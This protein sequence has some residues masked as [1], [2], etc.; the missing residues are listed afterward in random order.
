MRFT[1]STLLPADCAE[2]FAWHARPGA[3]RRLQ[4]PWMAARIASE[5]GS[6]RH[7][8]AVLAL[9]GGLR[10]VALHEPSKYVEGRRFADTLVRSGPASWP[11]SA[12]VDWQHTH[13][14]EPH[15]T[16]R[17]GEPECRMT[18]V[19]ETN[20]PARMLTPMFT[21]RHEQLA[22][23]LAAHRLAD[24]YRT[25]R[26]PLTVAM[27]GSSGLVGSALAAFL[28]TGGHRVIR[29][30][31]GTP[32]GTDERRWHPRDP[33]PDLLH[34]VDALV[35]LAGAP[36]GGRFTAAHKQDIRESRV[37]A[38][39]RLAEL[40]AATAAADKS[41]AE[42]RTGPAGDRG[43]PVFVC[44]SAI[45]IYGAD[46]GDEVLRETSARGSGFLADVVAEWEAAT[47]PARAA[48]VRVVNVRTGVV[49]AA[50]GGMLGLLRHLFAAGLGGRIGSGDQWLSWIGLDDLVYIYHRALVDPGITGP[51]NAVSPEPAR[52][53]TW[54]RTLGAVVRRPTLLRI[55]Q[56]GPRMLLGAEGAEELALANQRV[57][58]AALSGA[59]HD[60]RRP[61]LVD[62]LGHE[63]GKAAYSCS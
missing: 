19:V 35:H 43:P 25:G 13:E 61:H 1:F 56:F 11:V 50:A 15:D 27:T 2:V 18:D 17:S 20:V 29:L 10:W 37:P 9:P 33:H 40:L 58:P 53:A 62:A 7:G 45:G 44:A 39:R 12:V 54:T 52:N 8:R 34:G 63:L 47:E 5:A 57:L 46:R 6:L 30:V 24:R 21:Y 59:G 3:F 16:G 36:I 55:P 28:T 48:G 60:F 22:A 49:Q 32:R 51:I 31:R 26:G 23:D 4:P 42:N 41:A 14:F 38:T